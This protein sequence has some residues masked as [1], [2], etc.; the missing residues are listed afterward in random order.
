MRSKLAHKQSP[1]S[2]RHVN[3]LMCQKTRAA[4]TRSPCLNSYSQC[5]LPLLTT[6]NSICNSKWSWKWIQAQQEWTPN[7]LSPQV[8]FL[9]LLSDSRGYAISHA[10]ST[11]P[12]RAMMLKNP[13]PSQ[14]HCA[15]GSLKLRD[16]SWASRKWTTNAHALN[17]IESTSRGAT[18]FPSFEF[19]ANAMGFSF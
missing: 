13:S 12:R 1:V 6:R 17:T 14:K 9:S 5:R 10:E 2:P 16:A 11:N 4:V 3:V 8:F 15:S 18:F 19:C 7:C